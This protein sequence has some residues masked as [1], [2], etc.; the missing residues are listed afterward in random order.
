MSIPAPTTHGTP[1]SAA[2]LSPP[3]QGSRP[4]SAN[5]S[6]IRPAGGVQSRPS[7]A[8]SERPPCWEECTNRLQDRWW[9]EIR[10]QEAASSCCGT[11]AGATMRFVGASCGVI[12][13]IVS[14]CFSLLCCC[15]CSCCGTAYVAR[16]ISNGCCDDSSTCWQCAHGVTRAANECFSTAGIAFGLCCY[17]VTCGLCCYCGSHCCGCFNEY[18]ARRK[19]EEDQKKKPERVV[20]NRNNA[21]SAGCCGTITTRSRTVGR[22]VRKFHTKLAVAVG[23]TKIDGHGSPAKE[24][25]GQSIP[26]T[27]RRWNVLRAGS[28]ARHWQKDVLSLATFTPQESILN[29]NDKQRRELAVSAAASAAAA[30]AAAPAATLPFPFI[31]RPVAPTPARPLF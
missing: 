13:K 4:G 22:F 10:D 30:P 28:G 8:R 5:R 29:L 16:C 26:R 20:A 24:P 1:S 19:Y 17:D 27:F 25:L 15:C 14:G 31:I 9:E 7:S 21:D 23:H 12:T 18:D 3:G 11:C 2:S 6:R